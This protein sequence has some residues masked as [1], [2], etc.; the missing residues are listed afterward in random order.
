MT[1]SLISITSEDS[2]GSNSLIKEQ[3]AFWLYCWLFYKGMKILHSKKKIIMHQLKY[4]LK[5]LKRLELMNCKSAV[6]PAEINHKLDSDD[7]GEDIDATTF[8]QLVGCL[9]CLCNTRPDICYIIEI[10]SSFM[11]KPKWSHY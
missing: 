9:R 11:D 8:K 6:T 3:K 2:H 1:K 4:E 10:V 5:L 7:E